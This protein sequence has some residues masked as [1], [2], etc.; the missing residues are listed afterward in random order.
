MPT[1]FEYHKERLLK[2]AQKY[3]SGKQ[4]WNGSSEELDEIKSLSSKLQEE[5][6]DDNDN[7]WHIALFQLNSI[8]R[9]FKIT[10]DISFNRYFMSPFPELWTSYLQG[11]PDLHSVTL[12][13]KRNVSFCGHECLKALVRLNRLRNLEI[14]LA[15]SVFVETDANPV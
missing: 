7:E 10:K 8:L 3:L 9:V 12:P 4:L 6:D 2:V 13:S 1:P 5:I 11:S 14:K 15:F